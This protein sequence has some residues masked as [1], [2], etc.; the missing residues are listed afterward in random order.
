MRGTDLVDVGE[1][2]PSV[3]DTLADEGGYDTD[4][5]T[6]RFASIVTAALRAK[7]EGGGIVVR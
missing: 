6:A 7:A 5:V 1:D 3:L 4:H 2:D